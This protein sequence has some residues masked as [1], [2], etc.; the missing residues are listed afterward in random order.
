MN[1]TRLRKV[2]SGSK[3][4]IMS[5]CVDDC[6]MSRSKQLRKVLWSSLPLHFESDEL[7]ER[8]THVWEW[9]TLLFHRME[10]LAHDTFPSSHN[11]T[12]FA[13]IPARFAWEVQTNTCIDHNRHMNSHQTQQFC[14]QCHARA[15][16]D[17]R[18]TRMDVSEPLPR[19]G[20][21]LDKWNDWAEKELNH[22]IGEV[23]NTVTYSL[24]IITHGNDFSL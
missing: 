17:A 8:R 20:R 10:S 7:A 21:H 2:H 19:L 9:Q 1:P 23:T 5:T 22:M 15:K 16:H 12:F 3:C 11:V 24:T 13:I 4:A 6:Q 18:C 14:Q